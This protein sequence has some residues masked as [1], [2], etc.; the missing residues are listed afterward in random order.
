VPSLITTAA[1]TARLR[2]SYPG[3]QFSAVL[4]IGVDR[5]AFPSAT[6]Q[7]ADA[8]GAGLRPLKANV[9]RGLAAFDAFFS[10]HGRRSPLSQQISQA[11]EHGLRAPST[12]VL[13][14]LALEAATG[15]LMGVQDLDAV[16]ERVTLDV[17]AAPETFSGMRGR[18]IACP[19]GEIVVRDRE[20]II[21][22]LF[23]GPDQRTAAGE[24]SQNLL[25]YI[26]DTCP[27]LGHDH[28]AAVQAT[29]SF[30]AGTVQS[31]RLISS[32]KELIT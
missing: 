20:G 14:L 15:V 29:M 19:A 23:Q 27:T 9:Q 6:G 4:A 30:L 21:A 2:A 32:A 10:Q 31:V 5:S 22:S 13:A 24:D 7:F 25:F 16:A 26:F 3:M 17:L 1:A 11:A 8:V 18:T 12:P 28:D